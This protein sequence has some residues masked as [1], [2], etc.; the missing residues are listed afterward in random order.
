MNILM[1]KS[2]IFLFDFMVNEYNKLFN[3]IEV[4]IM[5][6]FKKYLFEYIGLIV[7]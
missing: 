6:D 1:S 5:N 2:K 7:K 4:Y 3:K